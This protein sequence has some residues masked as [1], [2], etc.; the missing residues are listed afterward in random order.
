[1]T[2]A[3]VATGSRTVET[4]ARPRRS[5]E[6]LVG[7]LIETLFPA[8]T[9]TAEASAM[10]SI[11]EARRLRQAGDVDAALSVLADVDTAKEELHQARWAFSEWKQMVR[12]RFGHRGGLL[13][14]QNTGRAA[15]LV[16]HVHDGRA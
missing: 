7:R 12:R 11:H 6:E 16:P 10:R 2:T 1:M 8:Q 13:Y 14:S 15:V 9:E 5:L 4:A 3:S